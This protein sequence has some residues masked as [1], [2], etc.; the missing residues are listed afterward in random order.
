MKRFE[1]R[2]GDNIHE[3]RID[4]NEVRCSGR[5]EPLLPNVIKYEATM[6]GR[7]SGAVIVGVFS[8]R[9]EYRPIEC[10]GHEEQSWP[11]TI[12]LNPNGEANFQGGPGQARVFLSG[13]GCVPVQSAEITVFQFTMNWRVLE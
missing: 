7:I 13:R 1:M 12:T 6:T 9:S 10:S 8:S 2:S 5:K 4:G 11:V 3:C